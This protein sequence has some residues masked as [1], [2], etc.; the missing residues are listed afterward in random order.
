MRF[1]KFLQLVLAAS[2]LV[3]LA[4]TCAS[5]DNQ[6][7][8][9][10]GSL[11]W[12]AQKA[13]KEGKSEITLPMIVEYGEPPA[14]LEMALMD[15]T[16]VVAKLL[17]SK[18]VAYETHISTWRKYKTVSRLSTQAQELTP[19][20]SQSWDTGLGRAPKSL[21]PL[22]ADEFLME[23]FGGTAIIDGVKVT[24]QG[25]GTQSLLPGSIYLMFLVF[26]PGRQHA[27]SNYGPGGLFRIDG[28]GRIHSRRPALDS[29]DNFLLREIRQR[30]NDQLSDLESLASVIRSH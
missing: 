6:T 26:D 9:A 12:R 15:N 24:V 18:T 13:H 20:A 27:G 7:A 23:D 5:Q 8:P 19:E 10:R 16:V 21:L 4:E 17:D 3:A 2:C 11:A 1:R 29:E 28:S 30:A 25:D 22:L 14:S